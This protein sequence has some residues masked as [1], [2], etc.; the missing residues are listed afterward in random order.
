MRRLL[1]SEG[2]TG[3]SEGVGAVADT[4]IGEYGLEADAQAFVIGE[5]GLQEV[6]H[7]SACCIRVDGGERDAAV[8]VDGDMH[9]LPADAMDLIAPG[10]P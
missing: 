7:G 5:R 9:I 6:K 3:V 4:V 10:H 1:Q 8:I 2:F